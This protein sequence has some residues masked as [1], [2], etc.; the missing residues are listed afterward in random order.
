MERRGSVVKVDAEGVIVSA[1][2]SVGGCKD[3]GTIPWTGA[4]WSCCERGVEGKGASAKVTVTYFVCVSVRSLAVFP[5]CVAGVV[6]VATWVSESCVE[7]AGDIVEVYVSL[8]GC[9]KLFKIVRK[10]AMNGV[11]QS[12]N[13]VHVEI[14]KRR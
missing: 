13:G 2:G 11:T 1:V 7:A 8:R 6:C 12:S 5:V 3:A 9:D 14:R 10:T 4:L